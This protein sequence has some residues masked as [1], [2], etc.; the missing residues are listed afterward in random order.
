MLNQGIYNVDIVMCIDTTGS[1]TP[2]IEEVK[3]NALSLYPKFL[4]AMAV[5]G[6]DVSAARVKFVV[7]GDYGYDATPMRESPF[8]SLPDQSDELAEF[9]NSITATGGGDIPENALEALSVALKSDWTTEGV[10]RRHV[11]VMFTDAPA[12][13]LGARAGCPGYPDDMPKD[14][15][16]LS[17][18]WEGSSQSAGTYSPKAGRLIAFVPND[19]SWTQL[20]SWNRFTPTYTAGLGCDDVDMQ[21]VLDTIVGSFD[22]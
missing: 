15:A 13:S 22:L 9:V 7:F 20:E 10:K 16:E 14:L 4:D 17:A 2:I 3:K 5:A 8:F 19:E 18:I 21:T 6:K 1:M 11:V 12:L